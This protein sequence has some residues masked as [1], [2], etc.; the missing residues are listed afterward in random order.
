M[1]CFS[2]ILRSMLPSVVELG[3]GPIAELGTWP[4]A[5]LGIVADL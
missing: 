3:T 1:A 2:R 4:L 5:E